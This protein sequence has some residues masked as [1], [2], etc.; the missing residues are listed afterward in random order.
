MLWKT[1]RRGILLGLTIVLGSL[2]AA[3]GAPATKSGLPSLPKFNKVEEAV[4]GHLRKQSGYRSGDILSREQV[5]PVFRE[6]ERIGWRVAGQTAILQAVLPDSHPLVRLLRTPSGK[7]FARQIATVPEG[8]DR[9]YRL[10]RLPDGLQKIGV[11]IKGPDGYLMI[12]YMTTTPGGMELGRMLSQTPGGKGFNKPT[13]HIY[14][15]DML[16][17]RLREEYDKATGSTNQPN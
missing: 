6:L 2:Q 8:Y 15:E 13:G 11:L 16:V 7:K 10:S 17:D 4:R 12:K 3:A 14:T 5:Q 1:R 9:L